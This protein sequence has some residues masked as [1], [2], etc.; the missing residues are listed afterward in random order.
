MSIKNKK[1]GCQRLYLSLVE[2]D[3][4][5]NETPS[6]CL[7]ELES[8]KECDKFFGSLKTL[9]DL[10]RDEMTNEIYEKMLSRKNRRWEKGVATQVICRFR[11]VTKDEVFKLLTIKNKFKYYNNQF[12]NNVLY[13]FWYKFF[14]RD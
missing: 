4:D 1:D 11:I 8:T 7:E 14:G 2:G 6:M 10:H 5:Y 12:Y 3:V 9:R 13:N